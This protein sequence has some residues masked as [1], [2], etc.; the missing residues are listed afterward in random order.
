MNF[1]YSLIKPPDGQWGAIQPD[2]SWSGMVNLLASQEIDI[3]ATDFTV[4]LERSAVMTF[5]S[6]I[7]QIYHSLF[8][9]NHAET[10]NYMAYIEPMHWLTWVGLIVLITTIPPFLF[11]TA[12]YV[13]S[14]IICMQWNI[15]KS[16]V[17]ENFILGL[18]EKIHH[19]AN[20]QWQNL[21]CIYVVH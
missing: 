7:T 2:G 9:K 15:L 17:N 4:T 13:P 12:K 20:L 11:L 18:V 10:F 21:M 16:L 19:I 6:P 14:Y 8:I 1:T 5:A 3:A